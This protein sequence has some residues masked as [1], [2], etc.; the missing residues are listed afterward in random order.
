[1]ELGKYAIWGVEMS[2]LH[3]G[4][5]KRLRQ[6]FIREGLEGFEPHNV[7][8]LVLFYGIPRRDTNVIAHELLRKFGTLERVLTA[9]MDELQAVSG[10]T[11]NAASLLRLVPQLM[12]VYSMNGITSEPLDSSRKMRDY[13]IKNYIGV[14]SETVRVICLDNKLR[15]IADVIAFEGG[16][17]KAEVNVRKIVQFA[18]THNADTIIIAHNHPQGDEIASDSDIAVTNHL[19]K[20]L[21]AVNINLLDHI[22]VGGNKATS[23]RE[24]GYFS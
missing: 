6:R 13:C 18:F 23:M 8:E 2:D 12:R 20:A 21:R 5:R 24:C 10:M 4:H 7:L 15:I 14:T 17:S 1:M 3:A 16:V 19:I 9:P 11:E 22:I